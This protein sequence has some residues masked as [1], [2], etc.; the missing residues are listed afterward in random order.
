MQVDYSAI[1]NTLPTQLKHASG[2]APPCQPM[3]RTIS[4]VIFK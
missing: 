3:T 2:S 1:M 4:I